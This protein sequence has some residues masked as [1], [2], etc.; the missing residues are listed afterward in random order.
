[1]K[2]SIVLTISPPH[3][4]ESLWVSTTLWNFF[5][6][7]PSRISK[8]REDRGGMLYIHIVLE[9]CRTS[10][11]LV[12]PVFFHCWWIS[13]LILKNWLHS[14]NSIVCLSMRFIGIVLHSFRVKV[15]I[16]AGH[17]NPQQLFMHNCVM[18][19]KK[20]KKNSI[21]TFLRHFQKWRLEFR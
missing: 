10:V 8:N 6:R 16:S 12:V 5:K 2:R 15:R 13:V 19:T 20:R 17:V 4:D 3:L 9:D 21:A 11:E 1:M 18:C 7:G 14:Q